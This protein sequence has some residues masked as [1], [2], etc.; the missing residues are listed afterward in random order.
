[1]KTRKK[2]KKNSEEEYEEGKGME[3]DQNNAKNRDAIVC[4]IICNH[5]RKGNWQIINEHEAPSIFTFKSPY[6]SL[7]LAN[8]F[9]QARERYKLA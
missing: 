7:P 5:D 9:S 3:W 8:F 2:I 4:T 1:M 6:P